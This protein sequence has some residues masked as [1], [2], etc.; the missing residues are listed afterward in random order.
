MRHATLLELA[1]QAGM[2]VP[3]AL[4]GTHSFP[5][6]SWRRFQATYDAARSAVRDEA[7]LRQL[8]TELA[9]DAHHDGA[10]WVEVQ[11]TPPGYAAR[12]GGIVAFT[13]LLL[14]ACGQASASVGVGLGVVIAANRTRPPWEAMTLA[15][16]AARH[17]GRGVVGFGL[18][19]DERQGRTG[20]FARAFRHCQGRRAALGAA[21]GGVARR[22]QRA[23]S[24]GHPGSPPDRARGAGRGERLHDAP[25]RGA[26]D[27][28]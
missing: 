1:A 26:R 18:S 16:L 7:A 14:D 11:V 13:E 4:D 20:D 5:P 17:A 9:E 12:F 27:R 6:G 25:A 23:A 21:R 10:G 8:V 22:R 19:N 2:R 3:T 24:R 28:A 15:R